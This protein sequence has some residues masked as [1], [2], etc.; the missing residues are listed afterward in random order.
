MRAEAKGGE[1]RHFANRTSFCYAG[2]QSGTVYSASK[3]SVSLAEL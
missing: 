1:N 3:N 2:E